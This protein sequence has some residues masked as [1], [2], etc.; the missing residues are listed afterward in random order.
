MPVIKTASNRPFNLLDPRCSEVNIE[1]ITIGLSNCCR[2]SGQIPNGVFYS[3][4]EH[5]MLICQAMLKDGHSPKAALLG[6]LHDASE[7]YTG[8]ISSPLKELLGDRFRWIEN[9]IQERILN[10]FD[11]VKTAATYNATVKTY[12][13]CIYVT[14]CISL[15]GENSIELEYR[16]Y[17]PLDVTIMGYDNESAYSAFRAQWA[18]LQR[19]I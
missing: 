16:S 3:V 9:E 5:S 12:D 15:Y 1:D 2:F 8:D 7:A 6:L 10:H 11:L 17:E 13:K 18:L 14:E 19:I 4:A